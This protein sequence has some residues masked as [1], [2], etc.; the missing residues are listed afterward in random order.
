[1]ATLALNPRAKF[2][3]QILETYEAGVVLAG[4]EVKS[5]KKGHISLRGA[6]V[7]IRDN[8]AT[9]LNAHISAY[10]PKN[11]PSDYDPTRTRKLLLHAK[12]IKSL[13]GKTHQKGLTLVAMRVY[14]KHNR[15][16]LEIGLGKGKK[17]IDKRETINKR[18]DDR[19]IGRAMRGKLE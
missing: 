7:V 1:M 13:I 16:K 15:I 11:M 5:V 6:Y 19:R 18:E 10:Q 2:D 8:Q 12:E 14:T 9:L 4:Y 17:K 3:Y